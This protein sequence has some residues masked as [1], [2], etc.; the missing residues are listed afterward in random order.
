[1]RV[2]ALALVLVSLLLSGC[3]TG[4]DD[5]KA[6]AE[7]CTLAK[8]D[9]F[10]ELQK[11]GA[12]GEFSAAASDFPE[13]ASIEGMTEALPKVKAAREKVAAED[14]SPCGT[15]MKPHALALIDAV[16]AGMQSFLDGDTKEAARQ[17]EISKQEW[18]D[19]GRIWSDIRA[20]P[21]PE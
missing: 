20:T 8:G 5:S 13:N 21:D 4:G 2:T 6:S 10:L 17:Y 14:W 18:L 11:N 12:Y 9:A 15:D 7:R 1:M 16:A 19:M 3:S